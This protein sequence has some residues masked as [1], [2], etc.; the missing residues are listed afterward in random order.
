MKADDHRFLFWDRNNEKQSDKPD[1]YKWYKTTLMIF[2]CS[3]FVYGYRD[4]KNNP[5]DMHGSHSY[6]DYV[7]NW[8]DISCSIWAILN[9]ALAH[10]PQAPDFAFSTLSAFNAIAPTFSIGVAGAFWC[11][12]PAERQST[13]IVSLHQHG[14]L[15]VITVA[16]LIFSAAPIR[17]FHLFSTWIFAGSY[18]ANTMIVYYVFGEGRDEIY[19]FLDYK[20]NFMYALKFDVMM[21]FG[22]QTTVFLFIFFI[23]NMK[24]FVHRKCLSTTDTYVKCQKGE[25]DLESE[26]RDSR[27]SVEF[28]KSG[29]ESPKDN[30]FVNDTYDVSYKSL[31]ESEL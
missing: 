23:A 27:D 9:C 12:L 28:K 25:L 4:Q 31:P 18:A 20:D 21:T 2:I 1:T 11:L 16:D 15:A 8:N 3:M 6:T 22:V 19:P 17:W 14:F 29:F 30:S 24:F 7:S 10:F 26:S 13:D 5:K